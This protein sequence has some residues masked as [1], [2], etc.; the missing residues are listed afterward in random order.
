MAGRASQPAD[1][2]LSE[3]DK[4]AAHSPTH[5]LQLRQA[6]LQI[7]S[8]RSLALLCDPENL[9]GIIRGDAVIVA[10]PITFIGSRAASVTRDQPLKRRA[11]G[12]KTLVR[13]AR[14]LDIRVA[15]RAQHNVAVVRR[16][17]R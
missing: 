17:A 4:I 10:G 1:A 3:Q 14:R 15:R 13:V 8:H 5:R 12:L 2:D 7:I 16:L 9:I 11:L 6:A